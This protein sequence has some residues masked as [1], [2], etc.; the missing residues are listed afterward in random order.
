M[1]AGR[2][3]FLSANYLKQDSVGGPACCCFI[4][5]ADDYPLPDNH[6]MTKHSASLAPSASF[7]ALSGYDHTMAFQDSAN[8]IPHVREFLATVES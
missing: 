7:L 6:A 1:S 8:I 4:T 5:P 2:H 3:A